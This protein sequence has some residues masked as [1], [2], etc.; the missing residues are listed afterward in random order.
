LANSESPVWE[1]Q[2][3]MGCVDICLEKEMTSKEM[4]YFMGDFL[5]SYPHIFHYESTSTALVQSILYTMIDSNMESAKCLIL[6]LVSSYQISNREVW[7]FLID[8]AQLNKKSPFTKDVLNTFL[9]QTKKGSNRA[10]ETCYACIFDL[11][12]SIG[13]FDDKIELLKISSPYLHAIITAYGEAGMWKAIDLSETLRN[14]LI[15]KPLQEKQKYLSPLHE[16]R[17][18]LFYQCSAV[19][20]EDKK[21]EWNGFLQGIPTPKTFLSALAIFKEALE[22]KKPIKPFFQNLVTYK[23]TEKEKAQYQAL[24]P[25]AVSI[26]FIKRNQNIASLETIEYLLSQDKKVCNW[27]AKELAL[28]AITHSIPKSQVSVFTSCLQTLI[29]RIL[30]TRSLEDMQKLV[31]TKGASFLSTRQ[32]SHLE[33]CIHRQRLEIEFQACQIPNYQISLKEFQKKLTSLDEIL[34]FIPKIW[35]RYFSLPVDHSVKLPFLFE[36]LYTCLFFQAPNQ[37]IGLLNQQIEKLISDLI[38]VH[39]VFI[40]NNDEEAFID[41]NTKAAVFFECAFK[42]LNYQHLAEKWLYKFLSIPIPTEWIDISFKKSWKKIIKIYGKE[43]LSKHG[44]LEPYLS[45]NN[46]VKVILSSNT[47]LTNKEACLL[48]SNLTLLAENQIRIFITSINQSIRQK[49]SRKEYEI[50]G[51]KSKL[52]KHLNLIHLDQSVVSYF[53]KYPLNLAI[54]SL[55]LDPLM[56]KDKRIQ[57][58]FRLMMPS[59]VAREQLREMDERESEILCTHTHE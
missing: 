36:T 3:A 38:F 1:N 56:K 39:Q 7:Q 46:V 52:H 45:K 17:K 26:L 54:H 31:C 29:P 4:A 51:L 2:F 59:L 25:A 47:D 20:T 8:Q 15:K 30:D 57:L 13:S 6:L 53:N 28:M 50:S 12:V 18:N 40:S 23:C 44:D 21:N 14:F 42:N 49:A 24:V 43:I 48:K 19:L 9:K 11:C 41:I 32:L 33:I 5:G 10:L 34:H 35:R 27:L 55:L 58:N 16:V 37:S 22:T